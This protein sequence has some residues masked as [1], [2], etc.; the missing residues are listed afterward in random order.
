MVKIGDQETQN[1]KALMSL[2]LAKEPAGVCSAALEMV[3]RTPG[4]VSPNAIRIA[5]SYCQ[6]V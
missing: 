4:P 2:T 1:L 6:R 5:L 3:P